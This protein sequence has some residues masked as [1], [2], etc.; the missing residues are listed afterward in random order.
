[1]TKLSFLRNC[2]GVTFDATLSSTVTLLLTVSL[3]TDEEYTCVKYFWVLTR[4]I[5]L[6]RPRRR[7]EDNIKMY[8]MEVGCGGMDWIELVCS[9]VIHC[10]NTRTQRE[11]MIRNIGTWPTS[12]QDLIN[13]HQKIF[14][15]FVESIDFDDMQQ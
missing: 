8:L 11:T 15:W 6:G 5:P 9:G 2:Y 10:D 12:K 7:W 1:M 14:S 13:K 3:S 4:F